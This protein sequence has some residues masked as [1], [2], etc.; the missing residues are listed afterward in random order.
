MGSSA[1][2][3]ADN[4][5]K[6]TTLES[7]DFPPVLDLE[8]VEYRR[9]ISNEE[10]RPVVESA[11]EWL[12]IVEN[13][14][15]VRPIIYTTVKVYQDFIANDKVLNKYDLWIAN[16][17]TEQPNIPHMIMWQFSHSWK[18]KGIDTNVDANS[19]V[20]D[21]NSLSLYVKNKGVR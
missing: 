19:F 1:K 5:I 12:S 4:F 15:G 7:G 18:T 9:K 16:P 3:Q 21:Y 17:G 10:F 13:E 14:Y 6:N 2:S 11:K 8:K 20:G